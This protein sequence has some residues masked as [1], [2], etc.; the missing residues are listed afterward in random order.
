MQLLPL[1]LLLLL[2]CDSLGPL[3][4]LYGDSELFSTLKRCLQCYMRCC[5]FCCCYCYFSAADAYLLLLSLFPLSLLLLQRTAGVRGAAAT[6]SYRVVPQ[7]VSDPVPH[8]CCYPWIQL[9][10]RRKQQQQQRDERHE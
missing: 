10:Q 8:S 7:C 5:C 4:I 1:L 3:D 9:Q 2:R 6:I